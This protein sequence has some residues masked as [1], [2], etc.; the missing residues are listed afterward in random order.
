VLE[1]LKENG[2]RVIEF[3]RGTVFAERVVEL[4]RRQ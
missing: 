4:V 3:S 2:A 1:V